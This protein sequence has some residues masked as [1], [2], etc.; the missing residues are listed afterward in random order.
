[1]TKVFN[2]LV[3]VSLDADDGK[4]MCDKVRRL[5]ESI[6]VAGNT[7]GKVEGEATMDGYWESLE[8]FYSGN[9]CKDNDDWEA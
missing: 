4:S 7:F 5:C 6:D 8:D 1:M 9:D 2:V 3:Q